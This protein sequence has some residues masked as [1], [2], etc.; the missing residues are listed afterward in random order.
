[1]CNCLEILEHCANVYC[2]LIGLLLDKNVFEFHKFVSLGYQMR[3]L[4]TV[5]LRG[6]RS[7]N[8]LGQSLTFRCVPEREAT[9]KDGPRSAKGAA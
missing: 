7:P 8:F 3:C 9:L 2:A 4:L 1:M 6:Q 5:L